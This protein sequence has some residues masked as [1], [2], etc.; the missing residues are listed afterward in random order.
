MATSFNQRT[1][2]DRSTDA[3]RTHQAAAPKRRAGAGEE[4]DAFYEA[5]AAA[6][7]ATKADRRRKHE[8]PEL[9]PP[10]PDWSVEGQRPINYAIKKNRGLTPHRWV[11]AAF[12]LFCFV[13]GRTQS[14]CKPAIPPHSVTHPSDDT[15]PPPVKHTPNT[16]KNTPNPPPPTKTGA[17]TSR[18]PARST[19][20]NSRPPTCAARAR[21]RESGRRRL[22]V[23]RERRP[24]S[25][26]TWQRAGS[27]G[28]AGRWPAASR[29]PPGRVVRW[30]GFVR[31]EFALRFGCC[32]AGWWLALVVTLV[33]G[34][35][36]RAQDPKGF[37]T[38]KHTEGYI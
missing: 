38:G 31:V 19:A 14:A 36:C 32:L 21:C 25:S 24:A 29:R 2:T 18:T 10:L 6:R 17:R 23:T 9:A 34:W 35:L 15:P 1:Q 28:E 33:K 22:R 13:V 5:A 3:P 26:P 4:G 7:A 30:G 11:S 37:T 27:W 12:V 16:H 8:V 20:S